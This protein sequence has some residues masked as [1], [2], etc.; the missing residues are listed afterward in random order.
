MCRQAVEAAPYPLKNYTG[1]PIQCTIGTD[2]SADATPMLLPAGAVADYKIN[3]VEEP[4][5]A[6]GGEEDEQVKPFHSQHTQNS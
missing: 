5:P 1:E 6:G 2:E 3:Q 4:Q